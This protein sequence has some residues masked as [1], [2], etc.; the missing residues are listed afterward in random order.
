MK[1]YLD[2]RAGLPALFF[3][4]FIRLSFS[5]Q[6]ALE[7]GVNNFLKLCCNHTMREEC[8]WLKFDTGFIKLPKNTEQIVYGCQS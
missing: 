1:E 3:L 8:F 4:R 5:L 6:N 7:C 2:Q